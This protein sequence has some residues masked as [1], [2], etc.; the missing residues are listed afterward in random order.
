MA[1]L[2]CTQPKSDVSAIQ[3]SLDL[4]KMCGWSH[5]YLLNFV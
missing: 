5:T 1:W 4:W 3:V 2:G